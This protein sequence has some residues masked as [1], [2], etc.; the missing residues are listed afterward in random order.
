MCV[1][2]ETMQQQEWMRVVEQGFDVPALHTYQ[3]L[4]SALGLLMSQG[5]EKHFNNGYHAE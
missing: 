2:F 1:K 4:S 3:V 5:T